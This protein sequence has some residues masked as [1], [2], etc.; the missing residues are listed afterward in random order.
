MKNRKRRAGREEPEEKSRK[1]RAE[2][3]ERKVC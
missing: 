2:K 1:R 3:E